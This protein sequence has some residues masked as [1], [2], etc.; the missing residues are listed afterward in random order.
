M[1]IDEQEKW[2]NRFISHSGFVD[3]TLSFQDDEDTDGL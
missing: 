1:P 3:R 2:I